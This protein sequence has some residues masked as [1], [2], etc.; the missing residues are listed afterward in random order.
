[1]RVVGGYK[2][3]V[4]TELIDRSNELTIGVMQTNK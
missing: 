1:M 4:A 3:A 2:K